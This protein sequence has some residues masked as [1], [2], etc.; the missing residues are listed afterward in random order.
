MAEGQKWV[1][2]LIK[3]YVRRL[4]KVIKMEKVIIFGSRARGDFMED[5]DIDLI[6]I[7]KD[8][9]G[10]SYLERAGL[11]HDTWR[12][13][14]PTRLKLEAIGYTEEEYEEAKK[15]SPFIRS[16][17]RDEYIEVIVQPF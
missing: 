11:L 2:N 12:E 3:K 15:S 8:F 13:I 10:K 9:K 1:E 4:S 7:S 16:L 6:I 17:I 5:S 14:N